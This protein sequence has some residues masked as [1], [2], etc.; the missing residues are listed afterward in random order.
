MLPVVKSLPSQPNWKRIAGPSFNLVQ[1]EDAKKMQFSF[2]H[3]FTE[4]DKKTYLAY[5][6][7]WSLEDQDVFLTI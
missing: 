2:G 6:Y 3:I 7:P 1:K 4:G 5:T